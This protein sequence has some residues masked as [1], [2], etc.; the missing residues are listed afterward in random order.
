MIKYLNNKIN[1]H[2][3]EYIQAFETLKLKIVNHPI[4]KYPRFDKQVTVFIDASNHAIG[5]VLTQEGLPV[6]YASRTLNEHEQNYSVTDKEF[7]A[8]VWSVTYFRPYMWGN[9]FKIVTD[10]QS[11][12]Y[13]NKN[14]N[15]K[16]FS[17]RNQ[18][19]LLKLSEFSS[20]I[21]RG[22]RTKLQIS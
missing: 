7:L 17:Q 4:L 6:C 3:P 10:H 21:S 19:W 8:I 16:E 12:K 1:V 5:A 22:K 18:R 11:I 14:Y 13:L 15:G 9:K 20:P 2:D